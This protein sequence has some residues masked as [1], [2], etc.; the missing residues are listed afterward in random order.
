MFFFGSAKDCVLEMDGGTGVDDFDVE[1]L[2]SIGGGE[3][4]LRGAPGRLRAK[5]TAS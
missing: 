4:S 5:E 3:W 1:K 2:S